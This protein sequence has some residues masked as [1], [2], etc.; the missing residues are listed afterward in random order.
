MGMMIIP[1][2]PRTDPRALFATGFSN[3]VGGLMQGQE[4]GRF[5][6]FAGTMDPEATAMQI[7]ADALSKG[8][9]PQIAM[10][11]AG[12]QQRSL[13]SPYQHLARERL[14]GYREALQTGDT[15]KAERYLGVRDMP[16]VNINMP[17][18]STAEKKSLGTEM[19]AR[20]KAAGKW[21]IG[22]ANYRDED[23][24]REW[25]NLIAL[26]T[27]DNDN[28]KKNL[29][30]A[31]RMKLKGLG[32]EVEWDPDD[33]K[34]A[35]AIGL[36]VEKSKTEPVGKSPYKEYPD[37]FEEGGVWKVMRGGKKYRIEE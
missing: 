25:K 6:R 1:Y 31:W 3:L 34:W 27:F 37:A 28:Q 35:E 26:N 29:L 14:G 11:L 8:I 21:R 13:L 19:D 16:T 23:L 33:P 4:T 20:I 12:I 32:N 10:G 36:K 24:F 2:D 9:D 15:E 18:F 22:K 17:G 30:A 7:V 5:G